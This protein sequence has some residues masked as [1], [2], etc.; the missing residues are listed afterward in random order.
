MLA[1]CLLHVGIAAP[2]GGKSAALDT[3][4]KLYPST[5]YGT[6]RLIA[7]D[8]ALEHAAA[9]NQGGIPLAGDNLVYGEF[10]V[11]FFDKLLELACPQPGETFV[12]LG[13]G[14]GMGQC[15]SCR[16]FS[17]HSQ[18]FRAFALSMCVRAQAVSC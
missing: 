17:F 8:A 10:D 18:W 12:D 13:S 11:E 7:R 15:I 14:A 4:S 5:D 1:T 9:D 6:R 2:L 3:L 16:R